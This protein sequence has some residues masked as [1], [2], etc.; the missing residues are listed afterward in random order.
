M[1]LLNIYGQWPGTSVLSLF[2]AKTRSI[3]SGTVKHKQ[4]QATDTLRDSTESRRTDTQTRSGIA[5]TAPE[6]TRSRAAHAIVEETSPRVA[7]A[8]VENNFIHLKHE[9]AFFILRSALLNMFNGTVS[10]VFTSVFF[11]ESSSLG[12][13]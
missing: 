7:E 2:F 13:R 3:N 4:Q 5:L 8:V 1:L 10:R 6:E 11:H 12:P 9:M